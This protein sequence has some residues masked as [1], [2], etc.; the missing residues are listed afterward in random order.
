MCNAACLVVP[1]GFHRCP[2]K[3]KLG[4]GVAPDVGVSWTGPPVPEQCG[5]AVSSHRLLDV[6]LGCLLK[7]CKSIF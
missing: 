5:R 2:R 3:V 4:Q 7:G 1:G 6:C